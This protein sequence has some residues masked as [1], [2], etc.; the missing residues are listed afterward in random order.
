MDYPLYEDTWGPV[1]LL[2]GLPGT[3]KD[4]WI[5]GHC[6]ELPMISLDAIREELSVLPTDDQGKVIEIARE[7]AREYL[8][9]KQ[10]FV[11]NATH[12]SPMARSKPLALFR[13]YGAAVQT[14]YLETDWQE[15]LRRNRS[16]KAAVP[17]KVICDMLAQ[18][19]P[20]EMKESHT[21]RW[22]CT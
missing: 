13:D 12:V 15:Q 18:L 21:V 3:G 14:V 11:W 19:S 7:R 16:R 22:L 2:S 5:A 4:T 1:I 6:P 8:R 10:S 20:P 17:E 9:R